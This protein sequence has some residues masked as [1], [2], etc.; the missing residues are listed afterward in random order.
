MGRYGGWIPLGVA[1]LVALVGVTVVGQPAPISTP[2][3][4]MF[5]TQVPVPAD[6][7]TIGAVFG[8][9]RASLDAVARGGDLWIRYPDGTLK[10]LT[11]AAGY[12]T[13]GFQG[14]TAIAVREPNVHWS[15]TK[16][17]FSMVVGASPQRYQY[18]EWRW[19]LYEITGLDAGDT[20]V[21]SKVSRQPAAYNNVSPVYG[22]D[23]RILFTSDRPRGGEAHL[24]PQLDEYEEAPTVSGIWSLDPATGDLFLVQQSPSGS[25]SPQVDS[26]GRLVYIRWDHL[27]RDQQAD[28]DA[29][30]GSAYGTYG[31]FDFSDE[32][33]AATRSYTR[34]EVFPEP[35][36]SRTDLLAGTNV[37]GHTFN[38]FF[39][40][41]INEDGTGEE[42]LNHVGRHEFL[43]YFD[44]SFNDDPNLRYHHSQS[45]R[46][47]P[48]TINGFLQ[49]KES[50]STPGTYFGVDAPE[51]STHAAGQIVSTY[52]PPT[53]NPD[54]MTIT[55]VTHRDT[56][57]YTDSPSTNHSGLYRNPLPLSDGRLVAVH[58]PETRRDQNTGTTA[59]PGSRYEFRLKTLRIVDGVHVPDRPLTPGLSK[60]ITYWSPDVLV[61][62]SGQL[63]ELDPVEVRPRSRPHRRSETLPAGE[64]QILAEQGI[65]LARLQAYLRANDLALIVSH[66]VTSR[67]HADLQQ[68]FNLRV[69]G[70]GAQTI[71]KAGK[72]YDV[73]FLQLVQADQLRGIGGTAGTRAGRRVLGR[74]LHAAQAR[75]PVV[76]NAPAGSVAIAPDGSVAAFVPARRAMSWQLTDGAGVPVVRERYWIT[77]QPGEVRVCASCHGVNTKDQAGA[78][79]PTNTPQALRTLLRYWAQ[80][81]EGSGGTAPTATLTITREGT[82]TGDVRSAAGDIACGPTCAAAYPVGRTVTL[83]ATAAS[84]SR[85]AGWSG[86]ACAGLAS[87][88]LTIDAA[89][90]VTASFVTDPSA[91]SAFTRYL[92]EGVTSSFFAT[93]IVLANPGARAA[94]TS[95]EFLRDDG[96]VVQQSTTV[97]PLAT[98]TIDANMIPGLGSRAFS[99]VITSDEPLA[100]DR[101]VTWHDDQGR[102]YGSHAETSLP[103][104]A[105]RWYLAE[106]ATHSGFDLFYLLQNPSTDPVDVRVRYLRPTSAPLEKTYRVPGRTRMNIWVD[107]EKFEPAAQPLL[108]ASDVSAVIDTL[109][110]RGIIVERAMYYSRD[111]TIFQAGHESAG[112][113]DLATR[114]YLA[115]GAT[116]PFFDLFL[117]LANPSDQAAEVTV[118]YLL[119]DGSRVPRSHQVGP[120]QRVTIWVDGEAPE[121]ASTAVSTVVESTN[122]VPIV[123]ERSMWWP[124][125]SRTWT[126]AHNSPGAT[127][128]GVAWAVGDGEV[129]SGPVARSTYYLVANP[130][131][132]PAEVKVTLLFEDGAPA[133]TTMLTVLPNSRTSIDVAS[134]FAGAHG[135][136]FGALIESVGATPAPIVVERAM[137]ADAAGEMWAAG[138][139]LLATRLR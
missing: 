128:T 56:S 49:I 115:E 38:D 87:C 71:G 4:I 88:T 11:A 113:T 60:S 59:A 96:V 48:N 7:T 58:T 129:A 86:D 104:P 106:G 36:S 21:I 25:F 14:A 105:P 2:Y 76:P 112:V 139:N 18:Q 74:F 92:A 122:G 127:V 110:G 98:R 15:G 23:D 78:A 91:P 52:A 100:V 121:L 34:T 70:G 42:T 108:A 5:V 40:W 137:Y 101:T 1:G 67:D 77:M 99:S 97:P 22:T 103:G 62:Y 119:P 35:R 73:A 81:L 124:G 12:G 57:S 90:V 31:T 33:A 45:P 85:F 54:Q 50:P 130:S 65:T 9:H 26:F 126:E 43:G 95:L 44:V 63:W 107:Q 17:V 138:S 80:H 83:V 29:R 3:P 24:Y 79:G 89:R 46:V 51:F 39:P 82:G 69:A 114:W 30:A 8:N 13:N 123:V 72:V 61:T 102:T 133:L 27:Q 64:Q 94:T 111:A 131:D 135:K 125:D 16:A 41:M 47:N 109:D 32:S 134:T 19:Q 117:L 136:R 55:Y 66:D 37:V 120:W 10:N 28:A 75:N 84:G 6:F 68:P 116:G 93:R 132:T 53:L 118:T 20:P